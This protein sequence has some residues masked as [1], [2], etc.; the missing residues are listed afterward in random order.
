MNLQV[1]HIGLVYHLIFPFRYLIALDLDLKF[2]VDVA[3]LADQFELMSRDNVIA[4]AN[5]LAPHYWYDFRHYR[6]R[7]PG[8]SVGKV[9]PGLQVCVSNHLFASDG[10]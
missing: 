9:R 4:V 6:R 10:H 8:T 2:V 7:H 3:E 5:D 1:F